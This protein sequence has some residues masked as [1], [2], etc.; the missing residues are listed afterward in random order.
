MI[1][2]LWSART[3]PQLSS[4]YVEYFAQNVLPELRALPGFISA[5]ILTTAT[6]TEVE[7]LVQTVWQSWD[8]ITAFAGPDRDSAAVHPA[9]AALLT[10]YDHRVRH[11]DLALS[12]SNSNSR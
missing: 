6:A 5:Q 11:F 4:A 9:A 8:S 10:T 3:T 1:V 7:I 2:R 12:A